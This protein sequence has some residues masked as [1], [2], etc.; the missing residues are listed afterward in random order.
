[1]QQVVVAY[2]KGVV[3]VVLAVIAVLVTGDGCVGAIGRLI[4]TFGALPVMLAGALLLGVA[5]TAGYFKAMA[6]RAPRA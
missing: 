5:L 1:M 4:A 3:A 2:F 6:A